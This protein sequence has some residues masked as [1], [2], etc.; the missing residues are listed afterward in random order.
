[1]RIGVCGRRLP[2]RAARMR[3]TIGQAPHQGKRDRPGSPASS[4]RE[5]A[6]VGDNAHAGARN[7][8]DGRLLQAL[9]GHHR[10]PARSAPFSGPKPMGRSIP[11]TVLVRPLGLSLSTVVPA[12]KH[13]P[14]SAQLGISGAEDH[15]VGAHRAAC[16]SSETFFR[17]LAGIR[18]Q[19]HIETKP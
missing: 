15:H 9:L 4:R 1:M 13:S 5:H 10:G 3:T 12:A 18:R 2:D 11:S 6:P 16:A 17:T 19:L 7:K 8:T 14:H